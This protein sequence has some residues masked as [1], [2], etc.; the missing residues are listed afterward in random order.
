MIK[1]VIMEKDKVVDL[2]ELTHTGRVNMIY[3]ANLLIRKLED[4][5]E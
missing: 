2:E 3:E 4:L 1:L 5:K